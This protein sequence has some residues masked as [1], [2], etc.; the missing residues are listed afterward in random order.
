MA[1][2]LARTHGR[3][4]R[5]L[6]IGCGLGLVSLV[7]VAAGFDVLASDYFEPALEFTAVNAVCQLV[8]HRRPP[9]C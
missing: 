5:L 4:Q 9:V 2:R 7:A 8:S 1:E 6:E 3:G